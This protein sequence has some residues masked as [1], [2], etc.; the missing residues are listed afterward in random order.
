MIAVTV[1]PTLRDVAWGWAL[2]VHAYAT[3]TCRLL[4]RSTQSPPVPPVL[5]A[6]GARRGSGLLGARVTASAGGLCGEL[7]SPAADPPA[8]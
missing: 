2:V 3:A 1:S 8:A 4:S 6:A 7:D 5:P